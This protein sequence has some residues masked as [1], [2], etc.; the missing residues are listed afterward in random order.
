MGGSEKGGTH[1]LLTTDC[2]Q[3]SA[4]HQYAILKDA[5]SMSVDRQA[6]TGFDTGTLLRPA[7]D[8]NDAKTFGDIVRRRRN[9][10]G[11][12]QEALADKAVLHRTH[13]SLIERG[14]RLPT[15]IALKKLAAAL[16]T[17]MSDL[18]ADFEEASAEEVP[19]SGPKR[20][21]RKE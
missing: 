18:L 16:G 15:F 14:K 4:I 3:S 9:A 20:T 1:L 11:I 7:V 2:S 13:L 12:G 10:L 5:I 8:T 19:P 21:R 6:V 17:T